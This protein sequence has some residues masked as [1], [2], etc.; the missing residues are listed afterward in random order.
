MPTIT[1]MTHTADGSLFRMP[2]ARSGD[3]VLVSQHSDFRR[4]LTGWIITASNGS[5]VISVFAMADDGLVP[6]PVAWHRDDPRCKALA[7]QIDETPG[8][9]TW[10][11]APAHVEMQA[12]RQAIADIGA[13]VVEMENALNDEIVALKEQVASNAKR[14]RPR[15]DSLA[16]LQGRATTA[17]E[18]E[19]GQ[20]DSN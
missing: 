17:S 15:K 9:G 6:F 7:E 5:N 2:T 12:L 16:T 4:P 10:D 18:R 14:G 11:F 20:P 1:D 13:K 8:M 3:M 19:S